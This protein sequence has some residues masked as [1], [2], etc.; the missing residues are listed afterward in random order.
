MKTKFQGTMGLDWKQLHRRQLPNGTFQVYFSC[1]GKRVYLTKD[2]SG[3]PLKTLE[4]VGS[5]EAILTAR[6]YKPSEWGRDKSLIFENAVENWLKLSTSS[7]EWIDQKRGIINNYLMPTFKG[8]D[9]RNVKALILPLYKSL[10]SNGLQEKTVKNIM[11]VLKAFLN[12]YKKSIP[13]FPD[14][15]VITVREKPIEWLTEEEQTKVIEHIPDKD[16]PIFEFMRHYGC[17]LNEAGGLLKRN[18]YLDNDPAYV[19]IQ[20][21]L[22]ENGKLKPY[23]K[24]KRLKVLPILP[25]LRSIFDTNGDGEFVFT[26]RGRPYRKRTF[27]YIWNRANKLSGIKKINLY[28]AVR[29]SFGCQRLNEGYSLD[30]IRAV[31]G[32]TNPK[33]TERYAGYQVKSLESIIRGHFH[34]NFT[35]IE[36]LKLPEI[37]GNNEESPRAFNPG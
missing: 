34:T 33:T 6:G 30:E 7:P 13:D 24:T 27:E 10:S 21:V 14:F 23:T 22:T 36:K 20:T 4:Q 8:K 9:I 37:T 16:K 35:G 26:R 25:E 29:H 1:N 18:V 5:A 3:K 17:R 19:V 2:F 12:F 15:P 11:G 28:N 31:M 32:H